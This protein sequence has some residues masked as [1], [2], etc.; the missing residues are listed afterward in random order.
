MSWPRGVKE[1]PS[2]GRYP[3]LKTT[4]A[5]PWLLRPTTVTNLDPSSVHKEIWLYCKWLTVLHDI[6]DDADI[7]KIATSSFCSTSL[8]HRNLGSSDDKRVRGFYPRATDLHV[9][10]MVTIPSRPKHRIPEPEDEEV[11]NH[12]FSKVVINSEYLVLAPMPLHSLL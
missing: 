10:N 5:A 11:F 8:Y 4:Q 9:I 12:F 7:V 6:T 3:L 1:R 2:R